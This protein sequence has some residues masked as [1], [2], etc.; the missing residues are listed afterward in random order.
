MVK[1]A[2]HKMHVRSTSTVKTPKKKS[3][4]KEKFG[5]LVANDIGTSVSGGLEQPE[6]GMNP[7]VVTQLLNSKLSNRIKENM[8]EPGLVN[9]T[10]RFA[11]SVRALSV[12]DGVVNYTYQKSPYRVFEQ[13]SPWSTAERDPRELIDMTIRELAAEMMKAKFLTVRV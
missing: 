1:G 6:T 11:E 4:R 7:A 9:R 2:K 13:T 3:P 12:A 10:G 8:G 5:V